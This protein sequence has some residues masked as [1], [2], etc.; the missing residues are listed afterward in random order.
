[1]NRAFRQFA[2]GPVSTVWAQIIPRWGIVPGFV[3]LLSPLLFGGINQSQIVNAC[4][5]RSVMGDRFW[6]A[7]VDYRND[8]EGCHCQKNKN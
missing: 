2:V 8:S 7:G 5:I 6:F 3:L 1:M 4:P